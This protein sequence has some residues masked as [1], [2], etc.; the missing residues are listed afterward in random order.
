MA[1]TKEQLALLDEINAD[2]YEAPTERVRSIA[3]GV[4]LGF[5]DELE[6]FATSMIGDDRPYEQIRDEIRG[7]LDAYN[8]EYPGESI[9]F[10]VLGALAPTALAFMMG[11][12]APAT[13][14]GGRVIQR[15][16]SKP[17]IV[18][19]GVEG[20]LAAYGTGR[21]GAVEDIERV[22]FGA[23][24][25][26]LATAFAS[27]IINAGGRAI[28]NLISYGRQKF[29]N[30]VADVV[31]K[32]VTQLAQQMNLLPDEVIRKIANGEI[33]ATNQTLESVIRALRSENADLIDPALKQ[34]AKETKDIALE[35]IR[36]GL[37]PGIKESNVYKKVMM[38]DDAVRKAENTAYK[39]VFK[40]APDLT[41]EIV[42]T[43]SETLRRLPDAK[44]ILEE[45]YQ[46]AGNIVP[47]FTTTRNG[48]LKINRMPTLED[49]EIVRRELQQAVSGAY[50]SGKGQTAGNLKDLEGKLRQQLNDFSEPLKN[51]RLEASI[52][53]KSRD[54]F[55]IGRTV[56]NKNVDEIAYELE[57]ISKRPTNENSALLKSFRAG[58]M[59]AYA[60]KF[61]KQPSFLT[62]LAEEGTQENQM[63]R[64]VFPEDNIDNVIDRIRIAGESRTAKQRVLF[65]SPTA[66]QQTSESMLGMAGTAARAKAGDPTALFQLAAQAVGRLQPSMN[67][68]QR[69]QLTEILV[70]KDPNMVKK[71]LFDEGGMAKL[72]QI[73][74]RL[75]N[76]TQ[77]MAPAVSMPSA[78]YGADVYSS[79]MGQ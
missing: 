46:S 5:A 79:M 21:E 57:K 4:T 52:V 51:A 36:K 71:A 47:F 26:S 28:D 67:R 76:I 33:M 13:T 73:I 48:A 50:R 44:N 22:P 61:R 42:D 2:G 3:Q 49:A 78:E 11:N 60:Q 45:A 32:E 68:A 38:D 31:T 54:Q 75:M 70:S 43:I 69:R 34:Q 10:E 72:Q 74:N 18:T 65:G 9:G 63:L 14:L 55:K 24:T 58:V 19:G 20:G 1:L 41:G 66:P 40:D 30:K 53:R 56:L 25:G 39:E 6:A 62:K 23:T 29:G 59:D 7:K 35:E 17:S 27:P 64:T 12:P 37:V 16:I 77:N 8:K 15:A